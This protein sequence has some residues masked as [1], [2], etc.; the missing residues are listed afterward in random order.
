MLAKNK[1]Y[2][3]KLKLGEDAEILLDFQDLILLI[4][5]DKIQGIEREGDLDQ[6]RDG[7]A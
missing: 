6:Y 5:G 7:Y 1:N 4:E 2:H 3:N